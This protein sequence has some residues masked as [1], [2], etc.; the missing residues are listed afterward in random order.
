MRLPHGMILV[1]ILA[2]SACSRPDGDL[3]LRNLR[4]IGAG[5][6]EF[7]VLPG[8]PLEMPETLASLPAPTPGGTNLTDQNPLADGVAA[9]GGRP[10]ALVAQGAPASDTALV[11]HAARNGMSSDIRVTLAAEDDAFQR[12]R[13]RFTK[14]RLF[15][16]VDRYN[17]VYKSEMTDPYAELR[18]FRRMGVST[19]SAPP[20]ERR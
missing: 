4:S 13:S 9:L 17:D 8:K 7:S 10:G 14:F 20:P 15:R 12:S 5:P 18:R 19:P 2:L 16:D 6:D 1:A 11:Q 3:N